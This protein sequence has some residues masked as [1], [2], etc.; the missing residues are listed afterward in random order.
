M[1]CG[2]CSEVF[3]ASGHMQTLD[4]PPVTVGARASIAE[5][6]PQD[7]PA[8]QPVVEAP[9]GTA[10]PIPDSIPDD[11]VSFVRKARRKAFWGRPV[12]RSALG[13]VAVLL[14]AILALQVVVHERDRLAAVE[15]QLRPGLTRL[16]A[17]IGCTVEVPRQI[18]SV[19]IDSSTFNKLHNDSYRLSFTVRNTAGTEVATPALELTLL[20]KQE[21]AVVRRVFLPVE[22]GAV[23]ALAP[24]GEWN[25]V[26]NFGVA[27]GREGGRVVGYRLLA[28]YP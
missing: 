4:P 12:V 27:G 7:D 15:P 3:D 10:Q 5:P 17:Q 19:V 16:C 6:V 2:H 25:A 11:D 8:T 28:F 20:D 18:E 23:A 21:Q 24:T 22:L 13:I 9:G 14:T 1:R 26:V